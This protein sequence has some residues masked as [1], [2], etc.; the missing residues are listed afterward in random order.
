M[1]QLVVKIFIVTL[2]FRKTIAIDLQKEI[3]NEIKFGFAIVVI[4]ILGFIIV[5]LGNATSNWEEWPS[6]NG[7]LKSTEVRE[8]VCDGGEYNYDCWIL[9]A[10][11]EFTTSKGEKIE[12]IYRDKS[13]YE[14]R[15][16]ANNAENNLQSMNEFTVYYNPDRPDLNYISELEDGYIH[17]PNTPFLRLV[18]GI[19]PTIVGT[20][21]ILG[22][23]YFAHK[24]KN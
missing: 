2:K 5:G 24:N 18:C 21:F 1:K 6:T 9:T 23:L 13:G 10:E 4:G 8:G 14:Y 20:G 15:Q 19:I 12:R 3:T 7:I 17:D 22:S 11:F 16:G